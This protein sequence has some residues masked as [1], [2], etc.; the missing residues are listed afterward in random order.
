MSNPNSERFTF[1]PSTAALDLG[2]RQTIPPEAD[3][4]L[5]SVD[6]SGSLPA[7]P[8]YEIL[9]TLGRGGMGV[10]YRARQIGLNRVVGLKVLRTGGAPNVEDARFVAEAESIARVRHPNV[11]EVYQAGKHEGTPFLAMEFVDGGSLAEKLKTGPL[12][13]ATAA[14]LLEAVARGVGASH[15]AGILHRDLK[16]GNVLLT[17]DGTPKVADFG[18][19]KRISVDSSITKTGQI[20]GTPCYMPPEQASGVF[21]ALGPTADV[22]SLGAVLY[23][24]LT[25]RPPLVGQ[26]VFETIMLVLTIDPVPPRTLL[27]T[28]PRDLETICMKCLQKPAAKRYATA[29]ELADDLRRFLDGAP[30]LARPAGPLERGAKWMKRNRTVS[31]AALAVFAALVAG[32]GVSAWQAVVAMQARSTAVA[33]AANARDAEA[34]AK[35]EEAK[36]K[37]AE[38]KAKD[39]EGKAKAAEVIAREG[40]ENERKARFAVEEEKRKLIAVSEFLNAVLVQSSAEGQATF[41]RE[42]KPNVTVKEAMDYASKTIAGKFDDQPLVE[43]SIR[44]TVGLAYLRLGAISEAEP[45]LKRVLELNRTHLG[46]KHFSTYM[47]QNHLADLNGM[48]QKFADA[49]PLY[50]TAIAGLRQSAGDRHFNTLLALSSLGRVYLLLNQPAKAEPL[51]R[52]AYEG[53]IAAFGQRAPTTLD[54]RADLAGLLIAKGEYPSAEKQFE[55][56][57]ALRREI[58]GPVHPQTFAAMSGLGLACLLQGQLA[59]AEDWAKKCYEGLRKIQGEKH[60][61]TLA[62]QGLLAM[63][64]ARQNRLD[65]ADE[66][67]RPLVPL[68]AEVNGADHVETFAAR[69]TL[70]EVQRSKGNFPEARTSET[71]LIAQS[72][73]IFGA[74]HFNTWAAISKLALIELQTNNLEEAEV[75]FREVAAG[76][77]ATSPEHP[78]LWQNSSLLAV[79]LERRGKFDEAEKLFRD[80]ATAHRKIYGDDQPMSVASRYNLAMFLSNRR[81]YAEAEVEWAPLV[82]IL[83]TAEPDGWTGPEARYVLG[84]ALRDQNKHADAAANFGLAYDGLKKLEAKL[85]PEKKKLLALV[86]KAVVTAHR[87]AGND[88]KAEEWR[89]KVKADWTEPKK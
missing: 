3:T 23:E 22:Y 29:D 79:V 25:G 56:L 75:L 33:E 64:Y 38:A 70:A 9:G 49:I 50:E 51:I 54:S 58:D 30:I 66:L 11:V 68:L 44:Q 53:R 73:R 80:V 4:G 84:K 32:A 20:L 48:N 59:S 24:C 12:P 5:D 69:V 81:R 43:A 26:D 21:T 14:R 17:G 39:E 65:L 61:K 15:K 1:A 60:P 19:A 55:D 86:A 78:I 67:I 34:K 2:D 36:A 37:V 13:P 72:K 57:L 41:D 87:S 35:D 83:E 85:P 76:L 27:P 71:E 88:A 63:V 82:P 8:G 42:A 47:A 89:E 18:L 16:P 77:R 31:V 28:I 74:N 7:I 62:A 52:E 10:V 40:E 6:R 45:H 46:E